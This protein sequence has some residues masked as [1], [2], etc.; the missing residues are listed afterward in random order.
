M[1]TKIVTR[2]GAEFD[3]NGNLMTGSKTYDYQKEIKGYLGGVWDKNAKGYR[4]DLAKVEKILD[5]GNVFRR[6]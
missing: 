5:I 1:T 2:R 6:A 4:V 3:L